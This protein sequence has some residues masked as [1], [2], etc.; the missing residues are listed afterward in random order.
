MSVGV[1]EE[2][3]PS[4]PLSY[5]ALCLAVINAGSLGLIFFSSSSTSSNFPDSIAV[6]HLSSS[7]EALSLFFRFLLLLLE[8]LALWLALLVGTDL[9][10]GVAARDSSTMT[11]SL[12]ED[13]S[14]ERAVFD[15][16]GLL[17]LLD[18]F[19]VDSSWSAKRQYTLLLKVLTLMNEL[20][21]SF[22]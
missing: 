16:F 13:P 9:D 2:E 20:T 17:F 10:L 18:F 5:I 4:A 21:H 14:S 22:K 7:L 11:K 19:G 3:F 15:F 12:E 1:V 8:P 6:N